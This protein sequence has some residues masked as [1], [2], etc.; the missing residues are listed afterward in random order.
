MGLE[1]RECAWQTIIVKVGLGRNAGFEITLKR[2][3]VF[4]WNKSIKEERKNSKPGSTPLIIR[5]M[6][7][8][9]T[10]RYHLTEVT[11]AAIKVYKQ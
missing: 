1:R 11:V 2:R 7:I 8:K 10:M 9:T 4:R 3:E 5:E 6:Q